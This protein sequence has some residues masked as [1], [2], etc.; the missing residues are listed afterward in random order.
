MIQS[1]GLWVGVVFDSWGS[2]RAFSGGLSGRLLLEKV[3]DKEVDKVVG[4]G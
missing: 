4:S 2:F 3:V 1:Q